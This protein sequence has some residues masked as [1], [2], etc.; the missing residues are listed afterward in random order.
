[1]HF[2]LIGL[3]EHQIFLKEIGMNKD[4]V[5]GR[6]K[7]VKGKIKEVAGRV[8]GSVKTEAKGMAEKTAGKVQA[9]YGDTKDRMSKGR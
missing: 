6:A 5:K 4:Q 3:T 7:E 2:N 8:S 9:A 1:L